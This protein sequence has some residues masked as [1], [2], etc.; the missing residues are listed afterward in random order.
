MI[1]IF[2]LFE[3]LLLL[4][5]FVARPSP[6]VSADSRP[7]NE[8]APQETLVVGILVNSVSSS[9]ESG[10]PAATRLCSS[11]E[12]TTPG[13]VRVLRSGLGAVAAPVALHRGPFL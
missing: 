10:F 5:I 13:M 3:A 6:S 12:R 7:K 11:E 4:F 8:N 1:H 9:S 2:V